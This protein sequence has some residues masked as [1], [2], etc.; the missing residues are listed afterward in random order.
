MRFQSADL[1]TSL[2]QYAI[3]KCQTAYLP[4]THAFPKCLP[5]DLPTTAYAISKCRPADLS[6]TVYSFK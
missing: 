2:Q 3:K 1:P 4:A 5:A 6:T